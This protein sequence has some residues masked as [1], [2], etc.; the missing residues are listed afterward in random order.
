MLVA[1]HAVLPIT[2]PGAQ[3]DQQEPCDS[4]QLQP[5]WGESGEIYSGCT[6]PA[7]P[8]AAFPPDLLASEAPSAATARVPDFGMKCT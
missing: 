3:P 4:Q 7:G 1:E 2:A 6:L 8:G 5:P